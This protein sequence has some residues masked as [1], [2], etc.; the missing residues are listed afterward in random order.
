MQLLCPPKPNAL[1]TA[2]ST[3]FGARLV[4]DVVE[5]A[6][7][8]GRRLVDRRRQDAALKRQDREDR[9]HRAG[10]AERVACRALRGRHGRPMSLVHPERDLQHSRLA[11]VA[12][13][14][15][16]SVRVHVADVLGLDACVGEGH[17]H[18]ARR[19]LSG[20]IRIGDMARRR[21]RRRSR[22]ARRGSSRRVPSRAR[23]L[24]ARSLR[25]PRPSRTRRARRRT[26]GRRARDP[27]CAATSR[28][29]R[30]SRRFRSSSPAPRCRRRTSRLHDRAES[31]RDRH[32]S[33]C[34]RRHRQSTP[35][36]AAR[37]YRARSRPSPPERFGMICT[38]RNG[39]NLSGPRRS[40]LP[41]GLLERLDSAHRRADR[42]AGPLGDRRHVEGGVGLGLT[43]SREREMR[44]SI[45]TSRSL[46]V[47][48][49]RHVEILHL[50]R[51]VHGEVG[52]V[53]PGDR[54]G[55]GLARDQRRP[56]LLD[57]VPER[58]HHPQAGHHDPA[59]LGTGNRSSLHRELVR[60]P[61]PASFA[62]RRGTT[63]PS[64]PCP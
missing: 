50:A 25:R 12:C 59:P 39:L 56:R 31:H 24:R 61:R 15:R 7:G 8:V 28:A 64:R 23:A 45:H 4:R 58:A 22:G 6:L 20:R 52:R 2:I 48:V 9:L 54:T 49:L 18:R 38:I 57:G 3:C 46:G 36:A 37:V 63:S 40:K 1:E 35:T 32:R 55:A 47:D 29:S 11:S 34:S 43:R 30:R 10:R 17:P 14:R 53:E 19:V 13:R 16:G 41:D 42:N 21:T 26:A 27:R 44:A 5:V 62:D 60:L 33:P 51:E